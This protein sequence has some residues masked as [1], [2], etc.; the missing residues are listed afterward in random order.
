MFIRLGR[1]RSPGG[2]GFLLFWSYK[3]ETSS[4]A[5]SLLWLALLLLVPCFYFFCFLLCCL[6]YVSLVS[7]QLGF[8]FDFFRFHACGVCLLLLQQ[9]A[10]S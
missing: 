2:S 6:A 7:L 10:S 1:F 3:E 9:I 8:L 5:M 4:F